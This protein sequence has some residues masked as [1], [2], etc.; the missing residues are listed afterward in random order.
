MRLVSEKTR[1]LI[2]AVADKYQIDPDLIEAMVMRESSDTTGATR[3]EPGF[4]AQYITRLKLPDDEGKKR[5]TSYGLLQIMYQSAIEDGFKGVAE[6]LIIPE[7]GLEWGV[8]HFSG[9]I[10]KY[11]QKDIN[12][13]ISAYNAGNVRMKDGKFVNQYYVDRVNEYLRKIKNG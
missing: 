1:I 2:E 9:K 8:K 10:K 4:N 13:A 6:D 7:I 12:R 5:S 11:G 3:Y